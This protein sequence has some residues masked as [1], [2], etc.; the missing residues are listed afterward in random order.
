MEK[1]RN[2]SW[3]T[4]PMTLMLFRILIWLI[5]DD[6]VL[7]RVFVVF[8]FYAIRS[9]QQMLQLAKISLPWRTKTK[10]GVYIYTY[11]YPLHYFSAAYYVHLYMCNSDIH[12]NVIT[13][14]YISTALTAIYL[15]YVVL[16]LWDSV[17]LFFLLSFFFFFF[18]ITTC[19]CDLFR[20][21]CVVYCRFERSKIWVVTFHI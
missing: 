21:T 13:N 4:A 12:L 6:L 7:I 16:P 18:P 3:V 2:I 8:S 9:G 10:F 5:W 11:V 1:S 15:L 20:S 19:I 14:V 17:I